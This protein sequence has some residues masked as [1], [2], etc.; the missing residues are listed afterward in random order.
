MKLFISS[1]DNKLYADK[2]INIQCFTEY[3]L[4]YQKINS[5]LIGDK[6]IDKEIESI[7]LIPFTH[8]TNIWHLMHQLFILFKVIKKN[9]I[10]P[11]YFY[12]IFFPGFYERQGE[13]LKTNYIDLIFRGFDLDIEKYKELNE[14]FDHDNCINVKNIQIVNEKI[15]FNSEPLMEEFKNFILDNFKISRNLDSIKS[16]FILRRGNREITNIDFVKNNL[17]S[18]IRYIYL[19]DHGIEK[20]LEI[21]SNSQIVIGVH[22]AGLTWSVFMKKNVL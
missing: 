19:E 21:I 9:N 22:G 17:P 7:L 16:T 2:K 12:F 4:R 20:Q 13:I 14:I 8:I 5:H 18:N 6:K 1:V 10:K 15:R 3:G 11:G